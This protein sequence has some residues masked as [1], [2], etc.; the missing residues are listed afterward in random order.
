MLGK[1]KHGWTCFSIDGY[2]AFKE[3]EYF[4]ENKQ[5]LI[6]RLDRLKQLADEKAH[7][8]TQTLIY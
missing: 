2:A 3:D 5:R 7:F 8:L 4:E 1:P 6:K